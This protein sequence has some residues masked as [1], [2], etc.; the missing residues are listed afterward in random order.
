M[1]AGGR[2]NQLQK[3]FSD[4]C[5]IFEHCSGSVIFWFESRCGSGSSDSYRPLTNGFGSGSWLFVSDLQDALL[6]EGSGSVQIDYGS[7]SGSRRP[8][9]I[10]IRNTVFETVKTEQWIYVFSFETN[11]MIVGICFCLNRSTYVGFNQRKSTVPV[12][13][14]TSGRYYLSLD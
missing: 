8:I 12:P 5:H 10:R 7:G 9:N 2:R 4:F 13:A 11:E 6:M 1:C 14:G 3:W